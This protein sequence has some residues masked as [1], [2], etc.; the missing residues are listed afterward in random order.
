MTSGTRLSILLVA[1]FTPPVGFSAAGRS[2][3]LTKYLAR[4]GHRVTVLTSVASGPGQ[5]PGAVRVVRTR[6]LVASRVNW[7][8]QHFERV[9]GGTPGAY[10][11]APSRLASAVVPDLSLVSWTPFALPRAVGLARQERFDCVVTTSPPESAHLVG[12]ALSRLSIPWVVDLQDGWTFE[13]THPE[14]PLQIQRRLDVALERAIVRRADLTSTV[15][16]PLTEDLRARIGGRVLTFPNGFDPDERVE[17]T[18]TDVGLD[19]DRFSLVHTGRLAFAGSTPVP[20]LDGLR[21]LRRS[22]PEIAGRLEIAFAGPLSGQ[23]QT[24][25]SAPELEGI[26]RTMGNL[27]RRDALALQHAANA[28]L[29]IVPPARPRSVATSKLYEYLAAARPILVLGEENAAA[30]IV[31][32]TEAGLVTSA[33]DGG[34]IA[35]A[36]RRLVTGEYVGDGRPSGVERYSWPSIAGR[37]ADEIASLVRQETP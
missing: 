28:L 30:Q 16:E 34:A 22:A 3:G 33:T 13:S 15:T 20:F 7:R 26:V 5:I 31:R 21:E 14:W 11:E 12:L 37:L 2:G 24:L 36:V 4:L 25:L 35:G 27:E 32:E 1:Q 17:A 8:R 9:K 19:P 29:L 18:K 10:E 23:E 6:D